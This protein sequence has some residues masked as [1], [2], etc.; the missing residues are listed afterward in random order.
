MVCLQMDPLAAAPTVEAP[1]DGFTAAVGVAPRVA[2]GMAATLVGALALQAVFPFGAYAI[3]MLGTL[4]HEIGHAAMGWLLGCPS[5]PAFDFS[6]GGGVTVRGE[7]MDLLLLAY[8]AAV[9]AF[10][11]TRR[12]NRLAL[13]VIGGAAAALG[14]LACSDSDLPFRAAGHLGE[15]AIAGI[16]LFR[17]LSGVAV[18]HAA[19]RW[20]YALVGWTLLLRA[21]GLAWG[22]VH[23]FDLRDHY[24]EGKRGIDNDLVSVGED[25]G[26]DLD[27]V[28][29]WM[30]VACAATPLAVWASWRWRTRL[31]A[32]ARRLFATGAG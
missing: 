2:A 13:G 16:F 14:I 25:L 1:A 18:A 3:S 32:I 28:C 7:R 5:L 6:Y 23:D 30:L 31:R 27:T 19:E 17:A 4:A 12:G 24:L 8:G 10:L 21:V 26:W 29:A 22:I 9:A 20:L 11:W 15:L